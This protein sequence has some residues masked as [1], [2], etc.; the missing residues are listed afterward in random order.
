MRHDVEFPG[1]DGTTLRGW[2]YVPEGGQP[3]PGIVM[4]HGFS[5]TKEMALDDYAQTFVRA[6]FTVLAY[7]HRCLG[8][9]DGEPRQLVDP[10]IQLRDLLCALDWLASRKEVDGTSLGVWG[11]SYSGGHALV[12]G[13]MDARVKAIVANVPFVGWPSKLSSAKPDAFGDLAARVRSAVIDKETIVGPLAVV[14]DGLATERRAMMPQADAAEWFLS[15]GGQP[16][17]NW[18]NEAWV[19]TR[20]GA[21]DPASAL[22]HLHG[23]ALFVVATGDLQAPPEEAELAQTLAGPQS[24]IVKIEG[25]HFTPYSGEALRVAANAACNF[26]LKI[27]TNKQPS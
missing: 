5:A 18:R 6:G 20:N 16:H 9:S 4:M 14:N 1:F 24:A 15:A 13:A 19:T 26:F 11:S 8:A 17:A 22:A 12:A 2:L 21:Y 3:A 23:P 27:L 7:D 25:H 10:W